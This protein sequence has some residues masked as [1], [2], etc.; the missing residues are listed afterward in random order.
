MPHNPKDVG[1]GSNCCFGPARRRC[2][3][4][5][6]PNIACHQM[7]PGARA[8]LTGPGGLVGPATYSSAAGSNPGAGASKKP[9]P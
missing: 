5:H 8:A 7:V 4:D 6:L 1:T 3:H 9:L 2:T